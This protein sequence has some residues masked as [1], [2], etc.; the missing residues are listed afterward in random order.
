MELVLSTIRGR[1]KLPLLTIPQSVLLWN[2]KSAF[3]NC[4]IVFKA[5][6]D[7]P[8]NQC[9]DVV[10]RQPWVV[11]PLSVSVRDMERNV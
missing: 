11:N 1:Y 8:T 4:S 9:F 5:I 10:N 3:D 7:L 2:N 6:A